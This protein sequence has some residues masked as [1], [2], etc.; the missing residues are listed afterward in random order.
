MQPREQCK[1]QTLAAY[2]TREYAVPKVRTGLKAQQRSGQGQKSS[3][4]HLNF[5]VE[6]F[7][8]VRGAGAISGAAAI[9]LRV[10]STR[11]SLHRSRQL[12]LLWQL[13][14]WAG[15]QPRL[16]PL[17]KARIAAERGLGTIAEPCAQ[18]TLPSFTSLLA[19]PLEE[20]TASGQHC[21]LLA[22][23]LRHGGAQICLPAEVALV[24]DLSSLGS[25]PAVPRFICTSACR[26]PRPIF[27]QITAV[28]VTASKTA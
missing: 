21:C 16:S 4:T 2:I 3:D 25:N 14:R 5:C 27:V 20:I 15:T 28:P 13:N 10:I 12:P 9:V 6:L 18:H 7:I 17:H 1:A 19:N 23:E 22:P 11:H 8:G 24:A 26:S